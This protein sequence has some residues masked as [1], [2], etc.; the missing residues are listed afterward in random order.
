MLLP[1][2]F[3]MA[4]KTPVLPVK[5]TPARSRCDS[6][7]S[8][9]ADA[10]P[11][12]KLITPGGSPAASRSFINQYALGMALEAGFQTTVFPISAGAV[13]RFPA[14]EVKLNGVTA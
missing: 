8:E 5:W 14:I 12:M 7:T 13:G 4:L 10:C 3:H 2:V 6:A 1:I 11:G 9:I